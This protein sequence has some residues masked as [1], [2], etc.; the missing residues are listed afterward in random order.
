[1][2]ECP[3]EA[4]RFTAKQRHRFG[5]YLA[6]VSGCGFGVGEVAFLRMTK[7]DVG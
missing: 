7:G 3:R 1:M 2:L 4:N 5:F 6:N